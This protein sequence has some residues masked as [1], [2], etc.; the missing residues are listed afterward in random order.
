MGNVDENNNSGSV[1]TMPDANDIER[2]GTS[3]VLLRKLPAWIT[4]KALEVK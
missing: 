4:R 1:T 3:C 2:H